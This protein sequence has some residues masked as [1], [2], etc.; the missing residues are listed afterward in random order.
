MLAAPRLLIVTTVPST[1]GAFLL[2]YAKHFRDLGWRVDAATGVEGDAGRAE[3]VFDRVWRISWS[4]RPGA[5]ATVVVAPSQIKRAITRGQ[6]DIVHTH[7][8]IASLVTRSSLVGQGARRPG[9][10]YTA[11]GFHFHT[12]GGRVGNAAYAA[13]ERHGA[14]WTDRLVVINE[15]DERAALARRIIPRDR[16]VHLPGIGIDLDHY[17][18]DRVSD[19][20][21]LRHALG[22]PQEAVIIAMIAELQPGKNHSLA[23]R[24]LQH[25]PNRDFHLC[26]AGEGPELGRIRAL[27]Q[28]LGVSERVRFLGHLGDTRPLVLASAATLLPSRREG[29]SRAVLES[30]ALG[31]PVIGATTRGVADLITPAS[32]ILVDPDDPAALSRA[33]DAIRRYPT[34][35]RLRPVVEEHLR[36]YSIAHLLSQHERLYD[37]VLSL[38]R[39]RAG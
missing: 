13:L 15:E 17:H 25:N 34:G 24:A 4:R 10:V 38:R 32:G 37:E 35:G 30:L 12:R 29:L 16:L 19:Q 27:S 20:P 18:P 7:T 3:S 31:V 21:D 9:V 14:R 6:Y 36:Q 22:L 23:L 28:E 33:F 26:L 8:P 39:T 5:L 11:H 2:P 1:L